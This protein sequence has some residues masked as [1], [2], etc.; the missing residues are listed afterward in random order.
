MYSSLN[1][2]WYAVS[3]DMAVIITFLI[4]IISIS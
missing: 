3:D 4:V 1:S 2:P